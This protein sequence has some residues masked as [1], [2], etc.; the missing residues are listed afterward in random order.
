VDCQGNWTYWIDNYD[1]QSQLSSGGPVIYFADHNLQMF[2]LGDC[3]EL[4]IK[5]FNIPGNTF[6]YFMAEGGRGPNATLIGDYCD[7]TIQGVVLDAAAPCNINAVNLPMAIFN[8]QNYPDLTNATVGVLS[9]PNFQGK[10]RFFSTVLFAGPYLDFNVN[11][12]DVGFDLVHMSDHAFLGSR[13]NGGVFRLINNSAYITYNGTSNFPPY[14]VVFGANAGLAGKVSEMIGCYSYNG[15][16]YANPN[17]N[18]PVN[19]WLD[20]ALRTYTLL[21]RTNLFQ[22]FQPPPPRLS[23]QLNSA[24][25][26]S[27]VLGW[28]A[29]IQAVSLYRTLDLTPPALW[30]FVGTT[31]TLSNNQW[32]VTLPVDMTTNAFYRLQ[33]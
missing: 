1:S 9:T 27:L 2:V 12:G 24:L 8:S 23:L 26:P 30:S 11:G 13:V 7:A 5:N 21:S 22:E 3:T 14:N 28:P 32:T 20:Y 4:L 17:T 29:N 6:L 31:P 18:N 15:Y 25:P 19:V 33:Q 16:S 10:A